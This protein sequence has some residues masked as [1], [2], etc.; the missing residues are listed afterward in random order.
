MEQVEKLAGY[1]GRPNMGYG[2]Q[3]FEWYS[4][5]EINENVENDKEKN[6]MVGEEISIQHEDNIVNMKME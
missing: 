5:I 1:K 2:Y 4:G 6:I 3:F